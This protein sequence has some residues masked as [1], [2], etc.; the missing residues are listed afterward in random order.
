MTEYD[1][2]TNYQNSDIVEDYDNK[3]YHHFFGRILNR[4]DWRAVA[5]ALRIVRKGSKLF[6]PA[7]GTGRFIP[8]LT[9]KG[10]R[11]IASDISPQ[12]ID[13]ARSKLADCRDIISFEID[14]MEKL[15]YEDKSFDCTLLIRF[16]HLVEDEEIRV[17]ILKELK[18]VTKDWL[19]VTFHHKYTLRCFSR[20]LRGKKLYGKL[21]AGEVK[22]TVKK[23]GFKLVRIFASNP[24]FSHNW[25]LLLKP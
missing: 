11:V 6:V 21:S 17:K 22:R 15:K 16:M 1:W 10:Y 24:P 18:R 3:R 25:V 8:K 5:R 14:D 7:C 19:I 4:C 2:K 23:A 9:E 12:M 20:M 13:Y